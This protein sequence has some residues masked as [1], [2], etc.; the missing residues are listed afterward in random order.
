MN[1]LWSPF[2]W[3]QARKIRGKFRGKFGRKSGTKIRKIRGTFVLQLSDG[4]KAIRE[5]LDRVSQ[6]PILKPLPTLR[7]RRLNP[8]AVGS[9]TMPV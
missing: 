3:K 4:E 9:E 1:F 6:S 8:A 2:P 7:P 5:N